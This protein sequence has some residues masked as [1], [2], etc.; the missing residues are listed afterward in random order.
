MIKK[1]K[2]EDK[3]LDITS[4]TVEIETQKFKFLKQAIMK[5]IQEILIKLV[6]QTLPIQA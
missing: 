6:L 1:D 3:K 5:Y 4:K 2:P